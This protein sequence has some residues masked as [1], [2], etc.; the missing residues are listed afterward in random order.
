M[1]RP[2]AMPDPI[3]VQFPLRGAGW[4]AVTTP[5]HRIPSHGTDLLGQRYAYDFV[6]VDTRAG[7]HA[8]PAPT[9][10]MLLSGAPTREFY[11]W[12]Q[13][14]HAP[15][16]GE[17]VRVVDGAKERSWVHPARESA[18]AVHVGATFTPDNPKQMAQVLGNYVIMRADRGDAVYVAVGHL[19]PRT[20]AVR[21]GQQ[22]RAGDLLGYVGHTGN[23]TMP[24]L[25]VQ[26]MD[27]HDLKVAQG[28]PLAFAR[29]DLVESSDGGATLVTPVT[30]G[31]PGRF[32]RIIGSR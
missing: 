9:W 29:Y 20:A 1:P 3:V 13:P 12:G 21:A 19:A 10:R 4:T 2:S 7:F 26:L 30:N 16:D 28:L 24:H 14:V 5:A 17:V 8:H 15:C 32:E 11:A 6:Q 31:V 23:S 27:S 18:R 25:H 22:V